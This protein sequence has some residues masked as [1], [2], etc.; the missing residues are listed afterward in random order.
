MN[1]VLPLGL[2]L[3]FLLAL[4]LRVPDLDQR[5]FHNDEAVNAVKALQLQEQG[6]YRYDPSEY[7]GPTLHYATRILAPLTSVLAAEGTGESGFRW[8]SVIFGLSLLPLLWLVRDGLGRAGT[9]WAAVL[10]SASPVL[11]FYSRDYI[12]E[13]LLVACTFGLI[14]CAWRYAMRPDW[15]WALGAGLAAGLM[16][17]TKE[18]FVLNFAA[19]VMAYG[20]LRL[21][22]LSPVSSEPHAPRCRLAHAGLLVAAWAIVVLT[23]FSSFGQNPAGPLDSVRTYLPWLSRAGGESPHVHPVWFYAERL[24]WRPSG[25]MLPWTELGALLLACIAARAAITRRGLGD[26]QAAFV[27]WLTV[28]SVVLFGIYSILPYKTPWCILGAAQGG[29]LLAGVGLAVLWRSA[30]KW[31]HR[32]LLGVIT[33]GFLV[34]TVGQAWA[35]SQSHASARGNPWIYA[36]TAPDVRNLLD[37]VDAITAIVP[38]PGRVDIQVACEEDDYW[39]LPFYLRA[40]ERVGYWSHRPPA[41]SAPV[42]IVSPGIA[43]VFEDDSEYWNVGTFQL[44]HGVFR[45]CLVRQALWDSFLETRESD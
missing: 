19:M 3:S 8:V 45:S 32:A 15:R 23:L 26:A 44:R 35:L 39:P 4:I 7:H 40:H 38:D 18:T 14:G 31:W 28:Y 27:I 22:S 41:P 1:R 36:D 21:T 17:A 11:V 42:L 37:L 6:T 10:T 2:C 30:C 24:F 34:Q 12:H 25:G 9:V 43:A 20:A 5:P 33:A 29:V 13:M 16:H